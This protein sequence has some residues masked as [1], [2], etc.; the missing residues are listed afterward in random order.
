M[1]AVGLLLVG[2]LFIWLTCRIPVQD[3][4]T[5]A[6]MWLGVL[7]VGVG[8]G[9]TIFSPVLGLMVFPERIRRYEGGQERGRVLPRGTHAG[10]TPNAPVAEPR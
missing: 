6:A 10:G 7:L 2:A 1:L 5:A 4:N 9:A 8:L 3:S